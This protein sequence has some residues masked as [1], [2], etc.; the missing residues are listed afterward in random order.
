V[1]RI[2]VEFVHN[3]GL[4]III[5]TIFVKVLLLPLTIKQ[6]K[7]TKA[8]QDIQ[9]KMK[10]IQEKYKNKPEKQQQEIMSL[11]KE[12]K[13]NPLAG[14][15]PLLIQMPI[16]F[17][18]YAVLRDPVTYG[19]FADKAAFVNADMVFLWVQNITK[20]DYILAIVSGVTTFV[21][22]MLMMPKDQQQGSMKIMTYVMSAMMLYWGF[23]L[24]A[25]VTLYWTAGNL[26]SIAQHYLVMNPLKAKL[27]NSKEEVIDES[28]PRNKK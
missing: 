12:A 4:S 23:M 26:F 20:P 24:P 2:I 17:G 16:L 19:V 22:Q 9:P 25:G 6:T 14:C 7:S 15:L 8:M 5:F 3:Y 18:L 28:K 1:L 10:E 11:Y 21:M 27:A 13:I